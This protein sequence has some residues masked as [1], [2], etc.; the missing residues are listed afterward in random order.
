MYIKYQIIGKEGKNVKEE[1]YDE[2]KVL[3]SQRMRKERKELGMTQAKMA[4]ALEL[5]L[6]SYSNIENGKSLCSTTT[7]LLYLMK[8]CPDIN[9]LMAEIKKQM[10]GKKA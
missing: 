9:G 5:D 6:R 8:I 4:E 1:F 3:L 2:L 10:K 7:F